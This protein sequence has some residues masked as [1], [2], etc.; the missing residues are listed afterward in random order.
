MDSFLTRNFFKLVFATWPEKAAA[1]KHVEQITAE[2][3]YSKEAY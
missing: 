3:P 2:R 1:P